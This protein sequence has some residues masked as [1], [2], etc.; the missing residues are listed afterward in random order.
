MKRGYR[1]VW[2]FG[3][4]CC[5][6]LAIAF[7]GVAGA[8]AIWLDGPPT[9]WNTAGGAIPT[10]PDSGPV[11]DMCLAGE[12]GPV[13]AEESPV[14]AANWR[15][16]ANWPTRRVG[17]VAVVMAT[18]GYDGMCRPVA[19]N[20]FVFAGGTFAGTLAPEPMASRTDGV[21][22]GIPSIRPD[23]RIEATFTRYA[24]TDPLCCPSRPSVSVT[25]RVE[26]HAGQPVVVV[27]QLA[28]APVVVERLPRT[29]GILLLPGAL[30]GGALVVVGLVARTRA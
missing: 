19:F 13:V 11:F 20:A 29:G 30:L 7:P 28:A 22:T 18:A 2:A 10:A 17:E 27:E 8:E 9:A 6:M 14:V 25:Y 5:L 4:A 15:L 23:G 3:V 26:D 16:L 1:T 24:S 21:L 12:R